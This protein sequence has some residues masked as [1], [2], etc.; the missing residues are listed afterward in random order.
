MTDILSLVEAGIYSRL[1]TDPRI[2]ALVG[3]HPIETSVLQI[4]NTQ[5]KSGAVFPYVMFNY[6]SGGKVHPT[7]RQEIMVKYRVNAIAYDAPTARQLFGFISDKLSDANLTL[8][9]L[10]VSYKCSEQEY[11]SVV[12]NIEGNQY[13]WR[14]AL[15]EIRAILSRDGLP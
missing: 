13:Y 12:Q 3:Y 8:G 7:Q 10:W 2:T 1:A 4:Y 14:G 6:V 15:Y 9:N 11:I 5:G